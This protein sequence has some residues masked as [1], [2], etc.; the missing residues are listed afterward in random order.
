MSID[1]SEFLFW[2]RRACLRDRR[3]RAASVAEGKDTDPAAPR[4]CSESL[5]TLP[6]IVNNSRQNVSSSSQKPQDIL[7]TVRVDAGRNIPSRYAGKAEQYVLDEILAADQALPENRRLPADVAMRVGRNDLSDYAFNVEFNVPA[8]PVRHLGYHVRPGPSGLKFAWNSSSTRPQPT[9]QDFSYGDKAPV[10]EPRLGA[11]ETWNVLATSS[12]IHHIHVNPFQIVDIRDDN[13]KSIFDADGMCA[14]PPTEPYR[15][16]RRSPVL[17]SKG[18][19]P[20]YDFRSTQFSH[21]HQDAVRAL[22]RSIR[23]TL[24][25]PR[26]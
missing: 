20:G 25:Y 3:Q 18:R 5:D 11:M 9:D 22:C 21:C 12:H 19:L 10:F 15:G 13:D 4:R 16:R 2:Q 1:L 6:S 23:S 8:G 17:R 24:P 14:A 26:P 7:M